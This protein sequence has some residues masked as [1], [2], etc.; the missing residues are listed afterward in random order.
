[1]SIL[2]LSVVMSVFNG[3]EYIKE[4]IESILNQSFSNFEFIII[5]DGSTDNTKKI[6][7]R[8]ALE[9]DRIKFVSQQNM[10]L[11][12]SLNRGIKRSRGKYIA[13]QDADDISFHKRFDKQM[14]FMHQHKDVVLCGTWF[15]EVN[16]G[17][18]SKIRKYPTNDSD[19]RQ[20][21]KYVNHFCHPSVFFLKKAFY[22]AGQYD[23]NFVTS[24]DFELW[25]R[26]AQI[27]KMANLPEVLVKKRIGFLKTISWQKRSQKSIVARKVI[28]KH[29]DSLKDID[30]IKFIKHYIPKMAYGYIPESIL[31]IVRSIRYRKIFKE[32]D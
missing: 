14:A 15:L 18:G 22:K 3:Q 12:R 32:Y 30:K 16:E 13:R 20:N 11:A 2:E 29:F 23:E 27:G 26:L 10:G 24:Q 28:N 5:N 9:D 21:L 19:L 4:S 31:K 25:I 7:E 8:Y 17:K 6:I 1:M